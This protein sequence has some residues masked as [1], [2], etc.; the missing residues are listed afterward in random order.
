MY[1]RMKRTG[2][3]RCIQVFLKVILISIISFVLFES[4]ANA[5]EFYNRDHEIISTLNASNLIINS[6][7]EDNISRDRSTVLIAITSSI[8]AVGVVTMIMTFSFKESAYK[9]QGG[10]ILPPILVKVFR[11]A[12]I[13]YIFLTLFF[14]YGYF[15]MGGTTGHIVLGLILFVGHLYLQYIFKRWRVEIKDGAMSRIS[16][17]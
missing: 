17:S 16:T 2:V 14:I 6:N 10:I 8:I 15:R 11:G 3:K 1:L 4:G 12:T 5:S 7:I 9:A 13:F